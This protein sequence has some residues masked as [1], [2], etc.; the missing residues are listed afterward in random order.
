M[1]RD[2]DLVAARAMSASISDLG[3]VPCTVKDDPDRPGSALVHLSGGD[4]LWKVV[5]ISEPPE[6]EWYLRGVAYGLQASGRWDD[7]L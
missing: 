4:G 3:K 7:P 5:R 1:I 2:E 6:L